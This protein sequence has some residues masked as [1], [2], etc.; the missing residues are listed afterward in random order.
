[1]RTPW[2][3]RANITD[4]SAAG[5]AGAAGIAGVT[6]VA[7]AVAGSLLALA[8]LSVLLLPLVKHP[9]TAVTKPIMVTASPAFVVVDIPLSIF[10]RISQLNMLVKM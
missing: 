2:E 4:Y 6:G 7:A 8:V 1:V 9:T 3:A 10:F 5:D